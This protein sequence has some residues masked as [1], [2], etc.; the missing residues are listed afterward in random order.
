MGILSVRGVRRELRGFILMETAKVLVLLSDDL[1]FNS[2]ICAPARD[3]GA[4][5][6]TARNTVAAAATA[7]ELS[8]TCVIVDLALVEGSLGELLTALRQSPLPPRVVAYGSHIDAAGL[9]A[10]TEAGCDVV[11]PR[12]KFVEALDNELPRWLAPRTPS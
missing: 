4:T 1:I 10:A 3:H 12:S 6:R 9:R 5:V 7:R 11:L 8:A 2:R